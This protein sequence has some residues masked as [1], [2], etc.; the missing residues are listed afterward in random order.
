L[1]I[2]DLLYESI[3]GPPDSRTDEEWDQEIE[4]RMKAADSGQ[5]KPIP[6]EEARR[7]MMED[8]NGR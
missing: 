8:E 5:S 4:R 3:G 2:A 7:Q 6:W 1:E